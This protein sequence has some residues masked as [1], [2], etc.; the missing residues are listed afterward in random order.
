MSPSIGFQIDPTIPVQSDE[1]AFVPSDMPAKINIDKVTRVIG[2]TSTADF[3]VQGSR[4]TDLDTMIWMKK[5]QDYELSHHPE[6]TGVHEY[7]HV[8][9]PV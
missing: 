8:Y 6:I 5:F 1:N 2:A 7:C 3:F 9:P 4:V